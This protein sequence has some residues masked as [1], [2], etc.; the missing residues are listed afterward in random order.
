MG[1]IVSCSLARPSARSPRPGFFVTPK[2]CASSG[3][4]KSRSRRTALSP[5]SAS[6]RAVARASV[7]RPSPLTELVTPS[8][9]SV[10]RSS[11]CIARRQPSMMSSATNFSLGGACHVGNR[12]VA[13]REDGH[14]GPVGVGFATFLTSSTSC[15]RRERGGADYGQPDHR[16][17][18]TW[19]VDG[20]VEPHKQ[21]GQCRQQQDP[22]HKTRRDRK[23]HLL[24][25]E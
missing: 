4:R 12:G 8:A 9:V 2:R 7:V 6:T 22:G 20:C 18:F 21:G 16:T 19:I 24:R 10:S 25:E 13:Y 23:Q 5:C 15:P 1:R 3:W 17:D 11:C 14:A